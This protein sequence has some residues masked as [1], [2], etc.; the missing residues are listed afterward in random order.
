M[1]MGLLT[2]VRFGKV[3]VDASDA[4]GVFTCEQAALEYSGSRVERQRE[5]Q[6][7]FRQQAHVDERS[8]VRGQVLCND[9]TG[10]C[11]PGQHGLME[12]TITTTSQSITPFVCFLSPL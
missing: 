12:K 4:E 10:P 9:L 11:P 8:E 6:Q 5:R 7:G 2:G 1:I 3:S